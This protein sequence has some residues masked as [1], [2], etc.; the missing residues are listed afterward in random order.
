MWIRH[1]IKKT[2]PIANAVTRITN[3]HQGIQFQPVRGPEKSRRYSHAGIFY[4]LG[5]GFH[6]AAATTRRR[7]WCVLLF[8]F[9]SFSSSLSLFFYP[10]ESRVSFIYTVSHLNGY[11]WIILSKS[12]ETDDVRSSAHV[13]AIK[14]VSRIFCQFISN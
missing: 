2:I 12:N 7:W 9:F 14:S 11:S 3:R 10:A 4:Q 6:A 5:T 1:V 13:L 8:L